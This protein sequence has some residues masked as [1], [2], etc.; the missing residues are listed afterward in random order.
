MATIVRSS[1]V[2]LR[3]ALR[4]GIAPSRTSTSALTFASRPGIS[5]NLPFSAL[6]RAQRFSTSRP[7]LQPSSS[8]PPPKPEGSEPPKKLDRWEELGISRNMKIFLIVLLSIFGSIETWLWT[9]GIL[10]WWYGPP[11]EVEVEADR[12]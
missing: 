9:K 3:A 11:K 5:A 12:G 2:G 1:G 10:R 6:S 8:P 7:Q 4:V